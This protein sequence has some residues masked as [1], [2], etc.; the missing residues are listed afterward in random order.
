MRNNKRTLNLDS[1][2]LDEEENPE[3]YQKQRR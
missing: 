1:F 2:A 3:S